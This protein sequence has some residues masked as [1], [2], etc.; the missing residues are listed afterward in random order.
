MNNNFN[1]RAKA[2]YSL[3]FNTQD[4]SVNVPISDSATFI[5]HQHKT[6][7]LLLMEKK[8]P[9]YTLDILM[10]QQSHFREH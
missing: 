3:R 1:P 2:I 9:I 8:L 6:W 10:L 7:K 5:I 4:N